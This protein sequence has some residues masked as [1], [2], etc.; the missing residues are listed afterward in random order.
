MANER[1]AYKSKRATSKMMSRQQ[2]NAIK[3]LDKIFQIQTEGMRFEKRIQTPQRY[4][5]PLNIKQK[6]NMLRNLNLT[7]DNS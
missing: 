2:T 7:I 4:K 6:L 1:V 5:R 3:G